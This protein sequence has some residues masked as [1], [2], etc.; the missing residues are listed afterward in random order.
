MVFNSDGILKILPGDS[1]QL[2]EP[3]IYSHPQHGV[4]KVPAGFITDLASI[5]RLFHRIVNPCT[6]GTRRPAIIH[7]YLY[8]GATELTRKAADLVLYDALRECGINWALAHA[9]YYAVWIGGARH[10]RGK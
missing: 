7:D 1:W 3:L 8:S 5:P 6:S 10:W 9:M 2:V 4:I